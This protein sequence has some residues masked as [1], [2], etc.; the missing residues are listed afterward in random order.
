[1]NKTEFKSYMESVGFQVR[2]KLA[3]GNVKGYPILVKKR[4]L[5]RLELYFY[6]EDNPWQE[7]RV[8]IL[9]LAK[10]YHA[11]AYFENNQITWRV[12]VGKKVTEQIQKM[13]DDIVLVLQDKGVKIPKRCI[14]CGEEDSDV[15]A[16]IGEG[17]QPVHKDCLQK[18]ITKV[19]D[20]MQQGRY[21]LGLIG[22]LLGCIVGSL[23]CILSMIFVQ[24]TFCVL[25]LFIPPC[26]YY[27]YQ[28]FKGRMSQFVFW[29][30][31]VFSLAS[32]YIMQIV[33]R[34][35]RIFMENNLM[36]SGH[37]LLVIFK[38]LML[39]EDIW[40]KM[41]QDA[42]LDFVFALMGILINWEL[43]SRTN[44]KAEENITKV[45]DTVNSNPLK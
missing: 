29:V 19:R 39:S 37:N 28:F 8:E 2:G 3:Y 16:V 7:I 10:K 4:F 30:S 32:V 11:D 23:P 21:S 31:V 41:T 26:V 43:I 27:G 24:D 13:W 9:A 12:H 14:L 1:M 22:G 33:V 18:E 6:L 20:R 45:I 17:N 36:W 35:Q 38:K 44:L 5:S 42:G 34:I 40:L 25:F 15:Y